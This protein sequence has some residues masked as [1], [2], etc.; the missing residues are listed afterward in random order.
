[1]KNICSLVTVYKPNIDK[2]KRNI[3][4]MLQYSDFVYLLFNSPVIQE[5]EFDERIKSIDN[6]RNIGISKA[7]NIGINVV[8]GVGFRY[9]MLFD[10]DS[11]LTRKNF[12]K[13][14]LEMQEE[15]KKQ[16][17][18]C[19]GPSLKVRNNNIPIY[20]WTKKKT[21]TIAKNVVS[22]NNIIT[23]G[24]LINIQNFMDIGGFDED[25]PVDFCDFVFCW[26]A[27]YKGY[28]VLQSED[29]YIV[30]EVGNYG[31]KIIGRTIHFHAPYRN[32]FLVRD[33]LNICFKTKEMPLLAR[34]HFSFFLPLRML[35]YLSL[36]DEKFK[37]LKMYWL[38]FWDFIMN[39]RHF[40]S[41]AN[42]LNAD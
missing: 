32:Y 37:R 23:S 22:V 12:E 34:F 26:K 10:Q 11:S 16:K 35:L 42:I 36:L 33:T 20:N 21:T 13:L 8:A 3:E 38:G 7:I 29:A 15:E 39:K 25:F 14:F 40:G 4:T 6:N 31:M 41:I 27:L 19:I 9:A 30:H 5:L 2:L 24:M 18:A 28:C 1:M 17:V